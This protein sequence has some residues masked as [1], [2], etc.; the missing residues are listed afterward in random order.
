M[1]TIN[2]ILQALRHNNLR[3]ALTGFAVAWGIFMLIVLLGAGNGL[4]NAFRNAMSLTNVNT[5]KIY[6]GTTTKP[7]GGYKENRSINLRKSD[8]TMLEQRHK[9]QTK[10]VSPS[11]SN[12]TVTLN[13][14]SDY[15]SCP[16]S[17]VHPDYIEAEPITITSGRF[18]NAKDIKEKRKVMVISQ[19]CVDILFKH[20]GNPV[21]ERLKAANMSYVIV[22]IC[23]NHMDK[24]G[25]MSY[26]PFT[27]METAFSNKDKLNAITMLTSGIND[28]T[29]SAKFEKNVRHDLGKKHS[30]DPTDNSAVWVENSFTQQAQAQQGMGYMTIAIWVIGLLTLL[31]GIVGVSNIMFVSVKERTHEIGVRRA[32]GAKPRSILTMIVTE[33]V[34]ITALFGYIG[35]IA[36]VM[37]T[38]LAKSIL[39]KMNAGED[40]TVFSNPTVGL[41]IAIEVTVVLIIAG[42]AAGFF[43]AVKATKISP[44]EA[45]RDE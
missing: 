39:D 8:A 45:L 31:S 35:M 16:M 30:F 43:P 29:T 36:G 10:E 9:A 4:T 14:Q 32:I 40:M 3:T 2:E 15:L 26:I 12:D 23:L 42:A 25:S 1:D 41:D 34:A 19:H 22:G 24:E 6:P 11:V 17:G 38:E 20:N 27:T 37:L 7:Y 5:V 28:T 21:G 44:V 18:I 33:S 13:S